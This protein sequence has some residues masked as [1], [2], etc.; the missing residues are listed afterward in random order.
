MLERAKGPPHD[1]RSRCRID[2]ALSNGPVSASQSQGSDALGVPE[3]ED[4]ELG[5]QLSPESDSECE[6]GTAIIRYLVYSCDT[7]HLR[8]ICTSTRLEQKPEIHRARTEPRS[9]TKVSC[10]L[11]RPLVM[12]LLSIPP[13]KSTRSC[14]PPASPLLLLGTSTIKYLHVPPKPS[15]T[16]A[17]KSWNLPNSRYLL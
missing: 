17:F 4:S 5:G 3:L 9:L 7:E 1:S 14:L 6:R 8:S 2:Q 12:S 11:S 10:A 15:P 13:P 16:E